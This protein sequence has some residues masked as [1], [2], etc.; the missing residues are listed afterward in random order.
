[1]QILVDC[2][3]LQSKSRV[4][5]F[6][7]YGYR[8]LDH[9]ISDDEVEVSLLIST[10][11]TFGNTLELV[12]YGKRHSL[13]MHV[14][15][16]PLIKRYEI[17]T[18]RLER[19]NQ[20][21][22]NSVNSIFPEYLLVLAPLALSHEQ[23]CSLKGLKEN[24]RTIGFFYD[25]FTPRSVQ[26]NFNKDS[27]H[28]SQNQYVQ[29]QDFHHVI[30]ISEYAKNEYQV[31]YPNSVVSIYHLPITKEFQLKKG[32]S[33]LAISGKSKHK[34]LNNLLNAYSIFLRDNITDSKLHVIGVRHKNL[35]RL[36][37]VK[38]KR[39]RFYPRISSKKMK[40]ILGQC[41]IIVIPSHAEGLGLPAIEGLE[42]GLL[43]IC[44]KRIATAEII[45][46][47]KFQFDPNVPHEISQV[48]ASARK[49]I[50]YQYDSAQADIDR[51]IAIH[52]SRVVLLREL[53]KQ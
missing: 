36:K 10:N 8:V 33:I 41:S 40:E 2:Q 19:A 44:S 23:T 24:I 21:Y 45:L 30:A 50:L 25:W 16:P 38:V 11:G 48:L 35:L 27:Q 26:T 4:K 14:F 39:V 9:L 46:M 17:N 7:N 52:N 34:N 12:R 47:T 51:M 1:M 3:I 28:N 22:V 6:G 13:K 43:P 20:A 5:G 32:E 31:K 29:L 42:K 49:Q 37:D 53:L 18:K 15:N